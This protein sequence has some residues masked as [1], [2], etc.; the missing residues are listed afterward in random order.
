MR[1][2]SIL[3]P[4]LM[5]AGFAVAGVAEAADSPLIK[6]ALFPFELEDVSA[7]AGTI[8]PDEIDR[9][10]LRLS[11]EE[12]RRLI[13]ASGRYQVVD[14]SAVND[15]TAKAGNLRNC[16]GCEARLA[17]GLDADQSLV[18]IVTRISR[19]EYAVTYK[20]RD[21]R[22]GALVDTGQTDLRMG[23]NVAWSRGAHWLIQNRLLEQAQAKLPAVAVAEIEYVDTSGEV[24]DQTAD[25]LRRLRQFEA[26][27]R[28]DLAA[29]GKLRSVVIDCPPT[30]CSIG[31]IKADQL[32]GK[33]Q[34]AGATYLVIGSIHKVSTLVQGG[35]FVMIDVKAGV[36]L[37]RLLTFR[38]D[39][40]EA[41]RRAESFVVRD[42]LDREAELMPA[43]AALPRS[44]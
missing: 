41:W 10:Q 34:A 28:S 38:G 26:S 3:A 33:A 4:A 14:V 19:T 37:N 39:S 9:E 42:I 43:A 40:D 7:G 1:I 20:V 24:I 29:S 21:V 15:P 36:V 25:H 18:G 11:T 44:P 2:V 8:P 22:S 5:L 31:D 16:E 27:L 6:L 30:A 17:A 12:A 35:K 23:A 32:L 13:A